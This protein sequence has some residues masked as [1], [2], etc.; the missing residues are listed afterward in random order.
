MLLPSHVPYLYV[1]CNYRYRAMP[2]LRQEDPNSISQ[3]FG[4]I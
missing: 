4:K 3:K 1:F 2:F